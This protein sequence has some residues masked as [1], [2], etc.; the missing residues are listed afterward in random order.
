MALAGILYLLTD[1]FVGQGGTLANLRS[2]IMS[3]GSKVLG[4][5]VLTGKAHSAIIALDR[6]TLQ[7]L[8]V[9]YG[10][11]L[12]NWWNQRFDCLTESEARYLLNTPDV[13]RIRNKIIEAVQG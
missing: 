6:V 2:H 13:D 9:K 10:Q 7:E 3:K 11:Q 5:I 1:Y 8:R 4:A 12:E